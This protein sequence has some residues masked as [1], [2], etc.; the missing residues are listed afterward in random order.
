M[1]ESKNAVT[2]MMGSSVSLPVATK[3]YISEFEDRSVE[4]S[5][6]EMQRK[7]FLKSKA[8]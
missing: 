5:Q 4:I 3:G 6:A 2:E 8:K 1:L 7:I